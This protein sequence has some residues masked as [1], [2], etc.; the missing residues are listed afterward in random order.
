MN[1]EWQLLLAEPLVIRAI[2]VLLGL[3]IAFL[4]VRVIQHS[5]TQRVEVPQA[6]YRMRKMI[7][8]GGYLFL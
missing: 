3:L 7:A 5:V 8:L 6:R 1:T 4:A 2:I